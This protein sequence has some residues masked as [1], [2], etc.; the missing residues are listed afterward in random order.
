MMFE[1]LVVLSFVQFSVIDFI[2]IEVFID[3][4]SFF[5]STLRKETIFP[6]S[7]L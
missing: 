6:E 4:E 1:P 3:E 5:Y 7:M 2:F